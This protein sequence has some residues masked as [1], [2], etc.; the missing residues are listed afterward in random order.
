[1]EFAGNHQDF[2]KGQQSQADEQLLVKFTIK[3]KP[4]QDA[5]EKNGRP[6]FRD[7][8]YIDIR[9]PG[10]HDNVCRPATFRDKERFPR[11]YAAF[12]NRTDGEDYMEGTPLAEW[13]L[14]NRSLVEEMAFFGIKTVEQLAN[15][16]DANGQQL[17]GFNNLKRKAVAWLEDAA[18][19]VDAKKLKDELATRDEQIAKL[20]EQVAELTAAAQKPKPRK[21][22]VAAKK[23]E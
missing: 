6:C 14:V 8:E 3:A 1:M 10:S 17:M 12:K 22:K 23:K 7:V 16:S 21:K 20:I 19:G 13:P 15:T 5:T 11:H 2:D 9:A 18:K 4:D